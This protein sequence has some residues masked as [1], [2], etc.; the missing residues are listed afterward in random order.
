MQLIVHKSVLECYIIKSIEIKVSLKNAGLF[1]NNGEYQFCVGHKNLSNGSSISPYKDRNDFDYNPL[2]SN[3]KVISII[4]NCQS[5]K[6][7]GK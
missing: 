4:E 2:L 3:D 5:I 7:Q 6:D 1:T